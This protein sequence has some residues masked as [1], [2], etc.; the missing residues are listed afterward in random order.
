MGDGGQQAFGVGYSVHLD[1]QHVHK[2]GGGGGTSWAA[3]PQWDA[4][5]AEGWHA[6][7]PRTPTKEGSAVSVQGG[8]VY[9]PQGPRPKG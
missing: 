3:A 1:T 4:F 6:P 5:R 2:G 7:Y 8:G 9:A